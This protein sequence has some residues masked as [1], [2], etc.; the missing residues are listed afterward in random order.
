MVAFGENFGV[1]AAVQRRKVKLRIFEK[2]WA[3]RFNRN[4]TSEL[5]QAKEKESR[6][7]FE[8]HNIRHFPS[9]SCIDGKEMYKEA[10]ALLDV[11]VLVA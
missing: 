6:L 5:S 9:W 3:K 8:D 7:S 2:R 11:L 10:F 1:G 4:R